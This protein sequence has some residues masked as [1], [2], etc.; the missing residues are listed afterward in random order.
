[1]VPRP[2]GVVPL[3]QMYFHESDGELGFVLDPVDSRRKG[4]RRWQFRADDIDQKGMWTA[5]LKSACA[6]RK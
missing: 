4:L 6:R 1:M 2:R 5:E 3:G